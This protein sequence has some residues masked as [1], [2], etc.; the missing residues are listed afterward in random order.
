MT[1]LS[2][3]QASSIP[4]LVK[5]CLDN[6]F[7]HFNGNFAPLV[8]FRKDKKVLRADFFVGTLFRVLSYIVVALLMELI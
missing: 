5:F 3:F 7:A 4:V 1:I 2:F 8:S 6:E